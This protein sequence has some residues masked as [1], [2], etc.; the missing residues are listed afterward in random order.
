MP[1][2]KSKKNAITFYIETTLIPEK[3]REGHQ[4]RNSIAALIPEA[5]Q[6]YKVSM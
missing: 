5:T 3:Q 4:F 1:A 6:R 2:K